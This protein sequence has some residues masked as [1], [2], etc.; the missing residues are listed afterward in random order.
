[1]VK[2]S[3]GVIRNVGGRAGV[4]AISSVSKRDPMNR[5]MIGRIEFAG[6]NGRFVQVRGSSRI[7]VGI[8]QGVAT[9]SLD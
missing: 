7:G 6:N 8:H 2:A 9:N 1:M 5:R 4:A 3:I